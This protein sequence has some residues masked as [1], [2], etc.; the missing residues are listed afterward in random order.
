MRWQHQHFSFC[1]ALAFSPSHMPACWH[2]ID[3]VWGQCLHVRFK[4]VWVEFW[5]PPELR[6]TYGSFCISHRSCR[7][8]PP[9]LEMRKGRPP[10]GWY[11]V[12]I[13]LPR[14]SLRDHC[15]VTVFVTLFWLQALCRA[16]SD[17]QRRKTGLVN[18]CWGV[19]VVELFSYRYTNI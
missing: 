16:L 19:S 12:E 1:S 18:W 14:Q 7:V 10:I 13:R 5:V 15:F 17:R 8:S 3:T 9:D 4:N 6:V 2:V 11:E